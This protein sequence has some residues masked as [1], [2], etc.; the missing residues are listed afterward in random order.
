MFRRTLP[1]TAYL[2]IFVT[3]ATVSA[4][5]AETKSHRHPQLTETFGLGLGVYQANRNFVIRADGT[6]PGEDI[7]FDDDLSLDDKDTTASLNFRWRYSENWS[8]FGQYWA[9]SGTGETVLAEDFEWEDVTFQAGTNASSSS[10]LAIARIFFGRSFLKDSPGNE[11]GLGLGLHLME[12]DAA[13]EGT[14]IIAGGPAEFRRE[15]ASVT[16]PLPNLGAW[17]LYSWSPNWVASAKAD[18]L[19]VTLGDYSGS[20]LSASVCVN[21]QIS[22]TFGLGLSYN[23]FVL[24]IEATSSDLSGGIEIG[25]SGPRLAL[26]AS[27]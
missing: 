14:A 8:L 6:V 20:L 27:F 1:I 3:S 4:Q 26:T 2:L 18:W 13:I 25:Q 5:A 16:F 10:D 7:D 11:F 19:S 21:Y 12:M 24:D 23:R 9:V 22:K 17:Y 15:E